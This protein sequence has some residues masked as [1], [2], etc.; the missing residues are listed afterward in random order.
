MVSVTDC[1]MLVRLLGW[2]AVGVGD[3]DGDREGV[4]PGVAEADVDR[5]HARLRRPGWPRSPDRRTT[6]RPS[7]WVISTSRG[8]TPSAVPISLST[9]SLAA[10][11][12]ASEAAPPTRPASCSAG[13]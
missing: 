8:S 2:G 1:V 6:G 3:G 7:A 9:A 11:R 13:V 12:A 5:A 10:N 4:V